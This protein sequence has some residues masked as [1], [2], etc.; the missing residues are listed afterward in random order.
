MRKVKYFAAFLIVF[1]FL[2]LSTY[3]QSEEFW[4]VTCTDNDNAETCRM[5]QSANLTKMVD[6]KKKNVGK[7]MGV[8]VTY[9]LNLETKKRA[10]HFTI[11]LPIGVDLR[12]G[13]VLKID[14]KK[15]FRLPYLRCTQASCDVS[16]ELDKKRLRMVLSGAKYKVGFRAWGEKDTKQVGGTLSGFTK[17]FRRLK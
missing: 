6:G 15:E 13:A 16:M 7:I 5:Q 8:V 14:D 11:Q 3:A 1:S 2:N 17:A 12:P 4:G 9:A 10:P